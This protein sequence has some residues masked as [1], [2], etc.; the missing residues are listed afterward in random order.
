METD[1]RFMFRMK[2]PHLG[3]DGN[4]LKHSAGNSR[5]HI[6]RYCTENLGC[7]R[8]KEYDN[9]VKSKS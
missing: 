7:E 2:C 6:L 8:M 5:G 3:Y 9:N 1:A 4:C